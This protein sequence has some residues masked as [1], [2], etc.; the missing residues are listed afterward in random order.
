[1]PSRNGLRYLLFDLDNTLYSDDSG[2][3]QSVDR[4]IDEYLRRRFA[5]PAPDVRTMRVSYWEKY[6]TTL[7]GLLAE[8]QG[9]DPQAYLDFIQDVP[10]E[11]LLKPDPALGKLLAGL[12]IAKAVFTNASVGYARRVLEVLGVAEHFAYVS[13]L[14]TRGYVSKPNL[15]AYHH[16]LGALGA[17]AKECLFVEDSLGNLKVAKDL[18]M[19]TIL[20]SD[21]DNSEVD[22]VISKVYLLDRALSELGLT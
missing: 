9:T 18:G 3:L 5:L 4:R 11:D 14:E 17:E 2:V 7:E 13:G 16:I 12:G 8:H 21:Q 10:V 20:I 15:G 22:Y 6:G 1:M 19:R